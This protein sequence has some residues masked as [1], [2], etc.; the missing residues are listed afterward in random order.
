MKVL[1]RYGRN[2]L[3]FYRAQRLR[4]IQSNHQRKMNSV[5]FQGRT[6]LAN[7]CPKFCVYRFISV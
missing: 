4:I 6:V 2:V 1:M 5:Q 3:T 7:C